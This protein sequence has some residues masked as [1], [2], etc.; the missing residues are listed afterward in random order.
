VTASTDEQDIHE[1]TACPS[2]RASRSRGACVPH[3]SACRRGY[4][5]TVPSLP[6]ILLL[7]SF[8]AGALAYVVATWFLARLPLDDGLQDFLVLFAP[9]FVA[10][11]VMLP[12]L[13][14]FFDRKARADLAEHRRATASATNEASDPEGAPVHDAAGSPDEEGRP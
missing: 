6:T 9:L 11:L 13:I 1:G 10:G 12:F 8:P 7:L 3:A 14:P 2:S 4:D 5:R